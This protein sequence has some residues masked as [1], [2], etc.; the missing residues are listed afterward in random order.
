MVMRAIAM[1]R[2]NS[3]VGCPSITLF[4]S[5]EIVLIQRDEGEH[6]EE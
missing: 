3:S 6:E 5:E 2:I 4:D 1:N